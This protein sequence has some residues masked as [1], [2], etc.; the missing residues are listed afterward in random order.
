[1]IEEWRQHPEFSD[2][3]VSNLGRVRRYLKPFPMSN[4]YPHVSLGGK[5]KRRYLH[6]LVIEAFVGLRPRGMQ[7]RHLD[8]DKNNCCLDN[9]QYG[10]AAENLRD[11]WSHGKG[12]VGSRHG[13]SK[14]TE[15]QVLTIRALSKEGHSSYQIAKHYPM[16]TARGIRRIVSGDLWRHIGAA[17]AT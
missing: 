6:N 11:R 13:M 2:I 16:M 3:E 7:T 5:K 9:L 15:E 4:G 17:S 8:G 10:T 12:N 1:M 14:V